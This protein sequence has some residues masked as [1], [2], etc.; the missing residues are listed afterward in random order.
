M[1]LLA[2]TGGEEV[3]TRTNVDDLALGT[4]WGAPVPDG[5]ER[6]S[7]AFVGGYAERRP[8]RD[9]DR[10]AIPWFVALRA[11]QIM[12]TILET[13]EQSPGSDTWPPTG[14]GGLPGGDLFDRALRFLH[15]WDEVYLPH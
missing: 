8:L 3:K 15:A 4:L 2:H 6:H 1:V 7:V 9:A 13:A 10:E 14:P 12:R 11:V 5:H